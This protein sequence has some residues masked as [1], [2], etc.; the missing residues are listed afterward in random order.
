MIC[1]SGK[2]PPL[3]DLRTLTPG[4]LIDGNGKASLPNCRRIIW[5]KSTLIAKKFRMFG[6]EI[7]EEIPESALDFVKSDD[8]DNEWGLVWYIVADLNN[9]A[10]AIDQISKTDGN[11]HTELT[12]AKMEKSVAESSARLSNLARNKDIDEKVDERVKQITSAKRADDGASMI[13]EQYQG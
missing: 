7:V 13:N 6:K 1:I 2:Y 10:R 4:Q 9:K 3:V 8:P 5:R 11:V 12:T